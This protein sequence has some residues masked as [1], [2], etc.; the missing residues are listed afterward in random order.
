MS[1]ATALRAH[2]VRQEQESIRGSVEEGD[3]G[4][5]GNSN[6]KE[7]KCPQIHTGGHDTWTNIELVLLSCSITWTITYIILE[8]SS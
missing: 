7:K 1:Q 6:M 2:R 5:N 8:P 3:K 4:S